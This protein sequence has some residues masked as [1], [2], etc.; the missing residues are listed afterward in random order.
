MGTRSNI[1]IQNTDGTVEMQY[2]HWDGYISH[3]GKILFEN[4]TTEE[5]VR[6][7]LAMGTIS[8]LGASIQKSK[9][10]ARDMNRS[11]VPAGKYPSIQAAMDDTEEYFYLF[12][13]SKGWM[14]DYSDALVPLWLA[15]NEAV[16]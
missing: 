14:V 12:V 7:L 6:E 15:V 11:V 8:S 3:N 10:H 5:Q 4:Y 13:P 2:C 1:A 9:F 16:D